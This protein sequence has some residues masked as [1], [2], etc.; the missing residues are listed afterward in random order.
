M[1]VQLIV[2]CVL[3]F[4]IYLIGALAYAARIAGV[5]SRKIAVSFAL[6][7]VLV[8]VSR[9]ANSFQAP[10]LSKRIE[11]NLINKAEALFWDFQILMFTATLATIVGTLMVPTT[12][13]LFTRAIQHFHANRS[14]PKLI[15]HAFAKGGV[16]YLKTA[17]TAPSVEYVKGLRE[18][19][20]VSMRMIAL[21]V[22]AQCFLALGVFASLYAGF[23]A[24]E[25]RVTAL[26]LSAVIN[27]VATILLFV[28]IDP[29]L[30]VMTDDVIEGKVTEG[31]FRRAVV[32]LAGSRVVGT[33]LAQVLLVPG[34]MLIA[35]IARLI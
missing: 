33:A 32:W 4:I 19:S 18:K 29:Q 22:I 26:S 10:F 9:A 2:L 15:M 3:T 11:L 24:P 16:G 6:F 20:I 25:F 21:N 8:L 34:A 1:D 5:R 13:R 17:V 28:M 27:G 35:E 7:N 30:S 12:Q 14:V 31:Q 23:I